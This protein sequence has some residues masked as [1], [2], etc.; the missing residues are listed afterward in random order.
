MFVH[1]HLDL[2]SR[3]HGAVAREFHRRFGDDH[4]LLH[5]D[6]VRSL[7]G[8]ATPA[9]L[10]KDST[11]K[12]LRENRL[13]V[14]CCK[15]TFDLLLKYLHNANQI[16][17]LAVLNAHVA[18]TVTVGDPEPHA[19][20]EDIV[21]R[22]TITGQGPPSKTDAFNASKEGRWGV[23][24]DC[25]ELQAADEFEEEKIRT[26]N[27][28]KERERKS[29]GGGG[30]EGGEG[31]DDDKEGGGEE[32]EKSTPTKS[33]KKAAADAAKEKEEAEAAEK[34]KGPELTIVSSEVPVPELSYEARWESIEDIRYRARIS[35]DALPSCAFYTFT[36]AHEHL[37]CATTSSDAALV[38][39]GFQDSVVRVWDMNKSVPGGT[40]KY[41]T[42][43]ASRKR[44]KRREA[45][46][47]Q[48]PDGDDDD[49]D[50]D[51]E[52]FKEKG[53]GGD[54]EIPAK[55]TKV[56]TPLYCKEYIGHSSAVHAVSLSPGN[57][58]LLSCSRDS[59]VRA[60]SMQL[61]MPLCA[62][63]SHNYP[64]WDVKWAPTGHYFASASHD[65]TARV[66]AM[67]VATPRRIMVGHLADVDVVTWH[68]NCNYIATGSSD[69]TLRLWDVSTGECVRIFTGHRG[70]IRSIAMSPD[71]KSMASGSDDGGILTWDLGSAKCERAFAGHAGAVYS[72]DYAG[73]D[74][75]LLA[76]GGADETVRL[77]DV[78]TGSGSVVAGGGGTAGGGTKK[79]AGAVKTLR[80][81]ST[82]VY[83]VKFTRRN[84]L[85][86]MGAR[87]P[88]KSREA[89][90]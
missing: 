89:V 43:P 61:E 70:G 71:G 90:A 62:Y 52:E 16:A 44:L 64:V 77:W 23:L 9:H 34:E 57:E 74:A 18:V 56:A 20:E 32:K 35:K 37:V 19:D 40:D 49:D 67:D 81:R 66:W 80:T 75:T 28:K 7:R 58:F 25:V 63:R 5:G 60:W 73:G 88:P 72:L 10:A 24:V 51:D 13:P 17:L 8:L 36:H 46:Y 31:E 59:T 79:R 26:A 21:A 78:T 2:V 39:G 6:V 87:A 82:P 68:P 53:G 27:A 3:D 15:Y 47:D 86:G 48:L 11:A 69:R 29:G 42:D 84:L 45:G 4:L 30:G 33:K 22:N 65:K 55:G 54:G 85:I 1:C 38:V 12:T 76:S 83:A 41:D 50:D 14:R